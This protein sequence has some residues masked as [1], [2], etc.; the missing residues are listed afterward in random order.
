MD[1]FQVF[2]SFLLGCS[3]A[4]VT[5]FSAM[6]WR[7]KRRITREPKPFVRTPTEQDRRTVWIILSILVIALILFLAN[8]IGGR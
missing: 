4:V 1:W 7:L 6:H 3:L 2:L 8:T 5:F